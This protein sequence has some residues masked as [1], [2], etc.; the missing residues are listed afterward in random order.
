ME[1]SE[2]SEIKKIAKIVA[3]AMVEKVREQ[4]FIAEIMDDKFNMDEF[5]NTILYYFGIEIMKDG[6]IYLHNCGKV[7]KEELDEI[8]SLCDLMIPLY[9]LGANDE[10]AN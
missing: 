9:E 1:I 6:R 2:N 4:G 7:P 5:C 8:D 10:N 3:S